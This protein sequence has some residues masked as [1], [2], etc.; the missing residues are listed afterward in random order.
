MYEVR[1]YDNTLYNISIVA[2]NNVL[3]CKLARSLGCIHFQDR[4]PPAKGKAWNAIFDIKYL[5]LDICSG[6]L[7]GDTVV[8]YIVIE[9][10]S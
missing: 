8:V 2:V 6:L 7:P 1:H 4:S 5:R 3:I 10:Q 9:T